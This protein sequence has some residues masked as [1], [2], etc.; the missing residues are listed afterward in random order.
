MMEATFSE[1]MRYAGLMGTVM[2]I[3]F[4]LITTIVVGLGYGITHILLKLLRSK[5]EIP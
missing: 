2:V 4:A 3:R 5:H 1:Y